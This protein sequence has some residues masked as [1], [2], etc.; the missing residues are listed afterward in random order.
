MTKL[1]QSYAWS[2]AQM[3]GLER[4]KLPPPPE[5]FV[6]ENVRR[7]DG[8]AID[9]SEPVGFSCGARLQRSR[10]PA[11]CPEREP[12]TDTDGHRLGR[13]AA[14]ADSVGRPTRSC[15]FRSGEGCG[16]AHRPR[17]SAVWWWAS[18]LP[19]GNSAMRGRTPSA[20]RVPLPPVGQEP[21]PAFDCTPDVSGGGNGII[22]G[23][24]VLTSESQ[25]AGAIPR[26]TV[27]GGESAPARG[28]M[29]PMPCPRYGEPGRPGNEHTP[30]GP[31][32][33]SGLPTRLRRHRHRTPRPQRRCLRGQFR[34][35][36]GECGSTC[37]RHRP[38][39]GHD[40]VPRD[41]T[42]MHHAGRDLPGTTQPAAAS[43][44]CSAASQVQQSE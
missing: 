23:R 11:T 3:N 37:A 40:G 35:A 31:R 19:V 29:R 36:G 12:V 16:A 14:G 7:T 38:N 39:P 30:H 25:P 4:H 27:V 17:A 42:P 26:G 24:P 34:P 22:G 28:P 8:E 33:P 21:G 6:P 41:A 44:G 20:G 32:R 1:A 13:Y 43:A 2:T 15:R 10:S 5:A 18:V 9:R